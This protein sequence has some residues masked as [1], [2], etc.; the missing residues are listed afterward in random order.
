MK[1]RTAYL[2]LFAVAYASVFITLAIE[3]GLAGCIYGSIPQKLFNLGA[4]SLILMLP[5]WVLPRRWRWLV[6]V[7][8]LLLPLLALSAVWYLRF[9]GDLPSLSAIL[10]VSNF[11]SETLRSVLALWR[12]YDII[13]LVAA[14]AT[15]AIYIGPLR[16][17]AES[18]SPAL[19]PRL[20]AILGSIFIYF[21]HLTIDTLTYMAYVRGN[22]GDADLRTFP[23]YFGQHFVTEIKFNQ[24]DMIN[25]GFLLALHHQICTVKES[26]NLR[27]DLT[28]EENLRIEQ[29][30]QARQL[31]PIPSDSLL[32]A[33]REKNIILIIVESLNSQA[34]N[35]TVTPTLSALIDS[36]GT[37]SALNI[38]PQTAIGCSGDG[39]MLTNTGLIPLTNIST[40]FAVG[41]HNTFPAL[42]RLVNRFNPTVVFTDNGTPWNGANTYVN[43]G[44]EQILTNKDYESKYKALG[45]DRALME[46][47]DSL[48]PTLRQP[49]LLELIT[50]S[51]HAPFNDIN[52][53]T[54]RINRNITS[55]NKLE[56]AYLRMLNY[57]DSS[58]AYLISALKAR[59]ML[60]NT[61][62]I[63]ASDHN[64]RAY[65]TDNDPSPTIAFIATN[66][67]ITGKIDRPALQSDLFPT[68]LLLCGAANSGL[69]N[70]VG[71][72]LFYSAQT[73]Q[74][75][76]QAAGISELILRGDFFKSK[77][78]SNK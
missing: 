73:Q 76:Q 60:D 33:N 51:T 24:A 40:A 49:F 19:K 1:P 9:W 45:F 74:Q 22:G 71:N 78:P 17:G 18:Y 63:L 4:E 39:Q 27:R 37:I 11:N 68:I 72:S 46:V 59:N 20:L 77:F 7:P 35:P 62:L 69:W 21:A 28:D 47:A 2:T 8:V 52:I 29:F 42:P 57:F 34:I 32:Q 15:T 56:Q 13:P 41:S 44:F 23:H 25:N 66:T 10:A 36:P 54:D 48:L 70:G 38:T 75:Q 5:Y 30:I 58:L 61:M 64:T 53:P 26:L 65:L 14:F 12:F 31:S 16:K 67:G 55:P 3:F 6:L 43:Y 50:V